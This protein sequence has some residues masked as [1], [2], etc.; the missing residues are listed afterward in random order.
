MNRSFFRVDFGD[1]GFWLFAT[2]VSAFIWLGDDGRRAIIA[3]VGRG[4][5]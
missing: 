3:W 5:A 1:L 2:V 4:C